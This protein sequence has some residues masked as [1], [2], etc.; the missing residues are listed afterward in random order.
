V[1]RI[2]R[3]HR[4]ALRLAIKADLINKTFQAVNNAFEEGSFMEDNL[5]HSVASGG[6]SLECLSASLFQSPSEPA[7]WCGTSALS[8]PGQRSFE[9]SLDKDPGITNSRF[10]L[11]HGGQGIRGYVAGNKWVY[12]G[13]PTE[14]PRLRHSKV[15]KFSKGLRIHKWMRFLKSGSEIVGSDR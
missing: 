6:T 12:R 15:S 1:A 2:H 10:R 7:K 11:L 9:I 14:Q 4:D 3:L 8:G 13:K 5:D